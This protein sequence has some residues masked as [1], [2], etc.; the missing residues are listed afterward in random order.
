MCWTFLSYAIPALSVICNAIASSLRILGTATAR[1]SELGELS[2]GG[3]KL[4]QP[5]KVGL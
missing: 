1:A 2:E 5:S 4:V 3:L